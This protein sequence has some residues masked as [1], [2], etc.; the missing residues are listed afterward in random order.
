MACNKSFATMKKALTRAKNEQ[1][2]TVPGGAMVHD[3]FPQAKTKT[4]IK[5]KN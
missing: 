5:I 4:K 1:K 2:N 3:A